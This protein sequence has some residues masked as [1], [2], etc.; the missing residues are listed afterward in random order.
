MFLFFTIDHGDGHHIR[1]GEMASKAGGVAD[2]I[3]GNDWPRRGAETRRGIAQA[4]HVYF[5][6]FV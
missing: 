5:R 1:C 2:V 3:R 4:A 6:Y